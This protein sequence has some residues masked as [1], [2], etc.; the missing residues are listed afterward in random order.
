MSI[1]WN[2]AKWAEGL[3][4][5]G[6]DNAESVVSVGMVDKIMV[7]TWVTPGVLLTPEPTTGR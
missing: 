5:V 6:M 4:K 1:A 7:V 2:V 3:Q